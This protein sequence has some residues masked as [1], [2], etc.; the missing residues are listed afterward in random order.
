VRAAR[1]HATCPRRHEADRLTGHATP[2]AAHRTARRHSRARPRV[3]FGCG[4]GRTRT[5]RA[6]STRR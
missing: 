6:P 4:F 5:M 1:L 2:A 3:R